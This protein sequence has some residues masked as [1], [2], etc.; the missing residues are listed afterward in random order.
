MQFDHHNNQLI[1]HNNVWLGH[2]STTTETAPGER[3]RGEEKQGPQKR[4]QLCVYVCLH[5]KVCLSRSQL[6]LSDK[7]MLCRNTRSIQMYLTDKLDKLIFIYLCFNFRIKS[8]HFIFI[9]S[10]ITISERHTLSLDPWFE[11]EKNVDVHKFTCFLLKWSG[12]Q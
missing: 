5:V 12:F 10:K 7:C 2:V 1:D 8:N 6:S 3:R 4:G 11:W 9:Q